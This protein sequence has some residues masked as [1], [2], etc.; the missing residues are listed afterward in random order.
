[1]ENDESQDL[2]PA[3]LPAKSPG[4]ARENPVITLILTGTVGRVSG[5]KSGPETGVV[6]FNT[7]RS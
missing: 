1:M 5:A 4:N 6:R 7:I 3:C 2:D